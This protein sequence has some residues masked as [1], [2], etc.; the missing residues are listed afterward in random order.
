MYAAA[1]AAARAAPLEDAA[2][3]AAAAAPPPTTP[4]GRSAPAARQ[5]WLRCTAH[6]PQVGVD[7][8]WADFEFTLHSNLTIRFAKLYPP[9]FDG[10][11]SLRACIGCVVHESP[12]LGGTM[13]IEMPPPAGAISLRC[14]ELG[15]PRAPLGPGTRALLRPPHTSTPWQARCA[16]GRARSTFCCRRCSPARSGRGCWR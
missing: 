14:E 6:P 5:A 8:S 16:R 9:L 15:A 3:G 7:A 11:F 13:Q 4:R 12:T 1:A 2:A 10:H